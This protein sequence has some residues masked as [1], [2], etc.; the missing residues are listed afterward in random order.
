MGSDDSEAVTRFVVF[1]NGEGDK[2]A[3]VAV[4]KVFPAADEGVGPEV[5]LAEFG[6]AVGGEAGGEVGDSVVHGGV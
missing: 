6:E 4:V 1:A 3:A 5:A 2:A